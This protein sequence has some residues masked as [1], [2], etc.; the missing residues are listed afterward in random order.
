MRR[1]ISALLA[2]LL[3][4]GLPMAGQV[5]AAPVSTSIPSDTT[6]APVG[7]ALK[8]RGDLAALVSGQTTLDERI[9]PL[10]RGYR[11]GEIPY[12]VVLIGPKTA[13]DRA[14]LEA[15]GV[16]VLNDYRA[17]EAYAV[18]SQPV[19]V[20]RV[21]AVDRVAWLAPVELVFALDEPVVDQ[22]PSHTEDVDAPQLWTEGVNGS[23]VR[24]AVLDTGVDPVHQD[25]DDLDFRRWSELTSPAKVV[26][27]R[28]FNGGV[29]R[30]LQAD[31]H[32]HG[33]H[34]AGI[35]TGTGE[36]IPVVAD[37]NGRHAGIAPG[38]ELAVGKVLTDAGAG[39]NSDL[40]AAMEWAAMPEDRLNC[41]IGADIVNLSLGSEARPTRLNS[42]G[43]VDMVSWALNR[44]AV[45]YGT[46]FVAAAGNSG[47]YIGSVLE[48]PGS[49]AQALS[50][51]A[52]AK[53]WD[54]NRDDTASGDTCAGW[55]HPGGPAT[56]DCS[57]GE[58][59]QPPSVSAFS[60]RG[61]SG[62]LWLRP[63]LA[64][65]GYNIVSAQST[66]GAP[67]AQNDLNRNTRT[68]PLYATATGT[69]MAAP[70]TAGSAALVLDAYRDRHGGDP[71]G[72]SGVSGLSA[73]TYAL[74]RAALMNSAGGDLFES[75]WILT[76]DPGVTFDC[77]E[78]DP[79][80]GLCA[81][82]ELFTDIAAG[83]LTLYEARNQGADPYVGPLAEGAG[84]LNVAR[85][86]AAL[87]DG[88]VIYSSAT[89]GAGA[90][91][92]HRDFQG[93]WQVGPVSAGTTH[94]QRFVLHAA[95]GSGTTP[96]SFSFLPGNPSDGSRA[97]DAAAWG[98]T[99]PG[100]AS[101]SAGSD[102]MVNL[103]L[104]V[105]AGTPPGAY[106]GTVLATTATGQSIRLPVF[107]SVA[108]HD[109]DPVAGNAPGPQALVTSARDVY[110][111]GDTQWPSVL[112]AAGGSAA[113]WL[114][115]PVE[116]AADLTEARFNVSDTAAGDEIYDLYL[117]DANL[118]LVASTH[119]FGAP[120]VTDPVANAQRPSGPQELVIS[121]PAAGRHYLAVSR[122]RVGGTSTGDFGS[123]RLTLDEIRVPVTPAA[124]QVAYEGD[125]VLLAGQPARL[126]A[127]LTDAAGVP[128]AGRHVAFTFDGAGPC[129]GTPCVGVT[130]Y[131]GLAQVATDP[132]AATAGV[133]EV[134]VAFAGD[135]HW[136]A[137]SATG[138]ALVVG[139]LLP[140]PP[141]SSAGKVTGGGWFVP[142]GRAT[143]KNADR[144]HIVVQATSSSPATPPSGHLGYRDDA[145]GIDLELIRWTSMA[146]SGQTVTLTGQARTSSGSTVGFR[147]TLTD[148]GEPGR[149][150]DT[151]QMQILGSSYDHTGV[152]GGG[153]IQLHRSN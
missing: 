136:Q 78:P 14:Q 79:L 140:P 152:L 92:G 133:H 129:G 139:D 153:N 60:S 68:D 143:T 62:D 106:T 17:V 114:V 4:V 132:L 145:A 45:Q 135:L 112:G 33:T 5:A 118:D 94:T 151:V 67:I 105:P 111:K 22:S 54:V 119:P 77:P 3:L 128:I 121:T 102:T 39:I 53:D 50:V 71:T 8:M 69:S 131:T 56:N 46:L 141:G 75:R 31:G 2:A 100:S 38:A 58:G 95:P 11:S 47:P 115:Y 144:V 87:R 134:G 26:D 6:A 25:L 19:D 148:A 9:P 76:T 73:P 142:Q 13:A 23:G 103:S 84:K 150:A 149:G 1:R 117:Y 93:S 30:P 116:L 42:D 32:G 44:L 124:T 48:A 146:V 85:A 107:A 88:V 126:S 110:A 70:A 43:D 24:I 113:D 37:D 125:Y 52:T 91:T 34:V 35:A 51:A 7:L 82:L 18:T 122:S 80:F 120:G 12:F 63:D 108:L 59:D 65:P 66:T 81:I 16:R 36:G 10:V 138:L 89:A 96:V 72:A 15:L 64:A 27:A 74:L 99:L 29:C 61:P 40:V 104:R 147:L 20:L 28:D 86:A 123:F 130:D 98:V 57:A 90:G 55:R 41:A 83:S 101:V 137:S 127:R 49:A 97:I 109:P 21:A